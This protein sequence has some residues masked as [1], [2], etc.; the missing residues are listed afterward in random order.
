[1]IFSEFALPANP[2]GAVPLDRAQIWKGLEQKARDAVPYV[3]AITECRVIDE[4]SD[5]VFDREVLLHG[6][7]Y[8]ER[9]WLGEPDRVVFTRTDGPV[10]GTIT[11]E[12]L[13]SDGELTLRFGFALVIRPGDD[14]PVTEEELSVQMTAAYQAAVESTLAAVRAQVVEPAR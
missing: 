12:V 14:L 10:L 8:V 7:R 2:P 3:A 11:N 13:E 4:I 9:V 5:S 1:M 6:Q